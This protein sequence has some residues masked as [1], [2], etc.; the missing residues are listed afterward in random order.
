MPGPVTRQHGRRGP[1]DP[2]V[3]RARRAIATAL[4]AL[5]PPPPG[6]VDGTVD[7]LV[8]CSGGADSLALAAAAAHLARRGDARIGA[9]VVDHGLH[10]DS[11]DVAARAAAQCTDLGLDPVVVDRVR[12]EPAGEGPEAA[13]R[14]ARYAALDAAARRTGARA[15]LLA[16][17]LDDQAEQVLLGLLRGSGTRSLAGMP[18][19]RGPY[20]RPFLHPDLGLDRAATERVCTAEGL[21]WW[22]DPANEDPAFTRSRI[23]RT[24]LPL[25]TDELGPGVAAGLARTA[26]IAARDAD[27]LDAEAA[28][29]F[30]RIAERSPGRCVL[31]LAELRV[32][33]PAL[34]PRVL[35][36]AAAAVGA[37]P[38][39]RERIGALENLVAPRSAT[40]P[41][42][43][44]PVPLPGGVIARRLRDR[45][46]QIDDGAD[47]R[48]RDGAGAGAGAGR[49]V[50]ELRGAANRAGL[51]ASGEPDRA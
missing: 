40:G 27:H 31:P 32:T 21:D 10:P 6:D 47:A 3:A 24:V 9:V 22:N 39:T 49:A 35:A 44:G 48:G 25:L 50:L 1:L 13:A 23:R 18:P 41:G 19:R 5:D 34:L 45:G 15:V 4:A 36:A 7:A 8:A 33:P 28:A 29:L 30:A 37:D 43:A 38:L 46:D 20:H 2:V 26:A 12:V 17:T 14:D 42:G 16:H 11:A 51:E